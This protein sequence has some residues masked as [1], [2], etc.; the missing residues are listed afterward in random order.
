MPVKDLARFTDDELIQ[1]LAITGDQATRDYIA[2]LLRDRAAS[3]PGISGLTAGKI[4]GLLPSVTDEPTRDA[5]VRVLWARAARQ[6]R[7][8]RAATRTE[9]EDDCDDA[10]GHRPRV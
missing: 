10:A 2:R 4:E 8:E 5:L 6:A 9:D 1:E 7:A 3:R